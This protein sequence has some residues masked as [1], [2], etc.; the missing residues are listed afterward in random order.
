MQLAVSHDIRNGFMGEALKYGFDKLFPQPTKPEWLSLVCFGPTLHDTWKDIKRPI[1]T[2]SGAHN[3]LVE[4][5]IVPDYHIECDPRP[6][7][8]VTTAKPQRDC[9]YVMASCCD[10][11]TWQNLSGYRVLMWHMDNGKETR[12]WISEH[13]PWS[14]VVGA[15]S[16]VG[17]RALHIA[18][19]LGYR[20]FDIHGMDGNYIGDAFR[21]GDIGSPPQN[22]V[23]YKI[24]G[25]RFRTTDMMVN[26]MVEFRAATKLYPIEC[27]LHGDGM[28]RAYMNWFANGGW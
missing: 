21:A 6:H 25:R 16:T 17:L 19:L 18:G 10:P 24:A 9:L 3:F 22:V 28:I 4:R 7:K 14:L 20:K 26:A 1:M 27:R 13:D 5:G 8:V 15:G 23:K 12:D 2:C 11:R